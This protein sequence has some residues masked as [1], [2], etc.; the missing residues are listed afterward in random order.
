MK[1]TVKYKFCVVKS[2]FVWGDNQVLKEVLDA[3]KLK[4]T[5]KVGGNLYPPDPE[6][7]GDLLTTLERKT[8]TYHGY[9]ILSVGT[10]VLYE[11]F[12]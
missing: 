1:P 9:T 12:C 10:S 7:A 3:K 4:T 11:S 6:P 5:A 8:L 2:P